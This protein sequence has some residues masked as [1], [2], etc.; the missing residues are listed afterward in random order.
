[1]KNLILTSEGIT[2]EKIK[3]FFLDLLREKNVKK[4]CMIVNERSDSDGDWTHYHTML[5]QGLG[6]DFDI[7]N[8]SKP[9]E[10]F[11]LY[12]YKAY[13]ICGGNTF[14]I[15]NQMRKNKIDKMLTNIIDEGKIYFSIHAGSM[16]ACPDISMASYGASDGDMADINDVEME[17][18]TALGVIPFYIFP[19]Y[20]S[21]EKKYVQEYYK[22][23][24]NPIIGITDEQALY[25][26]DNEY[27]LIGDSEYF[28]LGDLPEIKVEKDNETKKSI[29]I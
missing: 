6:Q 7:I 16:I 20:R 21:R 3:D 23:T 9:V 14:Y 4:I 18:L 15:L 13:Y 17:D 24:N 22:K 26:N 25:V 19:H 27:R 10:A 1:M 5:L 11:R 2:N 8:I 28:S 12:D 29:S